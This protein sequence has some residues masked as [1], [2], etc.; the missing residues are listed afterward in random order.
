MFDIGVTKIAIIGAIWAAANK[1]NRIENLVSNLTFDIDLAQSGD[2]VEISAYNG[3]SLLASLTFTVNGL[4]DFSSYG[5]I[6]RLF[7]D[8]SSS[9]FG[10]GYSTFTYDAGEAAV[11][12]PAALPLLAAGI[13]A[14]GIAG[15][16]RRA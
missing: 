6:T 10:V 4:A 15:Y 2:S 12:V 7:F 8:D 5:N 3:A 14:L 13:G 16:R 9:A 11:P 1:L